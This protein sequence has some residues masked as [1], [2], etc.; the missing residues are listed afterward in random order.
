[1]SQPLVSVILPVYNGAQYLAD[2]LDSIFAQDYRPFEVIVVDDGSTDDS[3]KIAQSYQ[4]IRYIYQENQGV[5]VAR[6]AGIAAAQGE[7]VA[8]SDQDDLW[9]SHK[10][11]LQME[12]LL[13]HPEVQYVLCKKRLFLEPGIKPP[14]WLRKELLESDQLDFSPSALVARKEVFQQIGQFN[15]ELQTASD[16]DWMFKAK[17]AHIPMKTIEDVLVHKRIHAGNQSY[18]VDA[19]HK[20]YLKLIRASIQQQRKQK[21]SSS[22]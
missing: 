15:S 1:M 4:Q 17:D 6:N 16:V 8:F 5:P 3:A 21:L 7:F 9:I 19:L 10:L 12:Y 20:E 14:P 22:E 2:T 11:S 13:Q 18:Q